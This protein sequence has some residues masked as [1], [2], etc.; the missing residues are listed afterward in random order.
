[1]R[2]LFGQL[3]K[4]RAIAGT[5]LERN[6]HLYLKTSPIDLPRQ[7]SIRIGRTSNGIAFFGAMKLGHN[8]V[9]ILGRG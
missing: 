1:V 4:E 3:L 5:F 8:L 7:K 6:L 2:K 9:N